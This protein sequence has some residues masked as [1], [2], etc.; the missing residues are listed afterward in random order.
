MY[1]L[2]KIFQ[3]RKDA[4][5]TTYCFFLDVQKTYGTV[6]RNRLWKRMWGIGVRGKR[7]R[8]MEKMTEGALYFV[9]LDGE[10][11]QCVDICKELRS[12]VHYH[13]I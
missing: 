3:G 8:M 11:S 9:M 6:W 5:L 1:T 12:D 13:P 2:D 4:G 10:I 7:W